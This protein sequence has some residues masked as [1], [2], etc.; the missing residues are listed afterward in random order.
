MITFTDTSV[1]TLIGFIPLVLL[2]SLASDAGEFDRLEGEALSKATISTDAVA[3][4]SLD[5]RAIDA[6]PPGLPDSRSAFLIVKTDAGNYTRLLVS[7][8]LRKP[9]AG[10]EAVPIVVID[11]FETFEPAKSGSRVAR[12]A[13]VALFE[14][15]QIDLDTGLVV[16]TGQGG[17]LEFAKGDKASVSLRPV[18]PSKLFSLSHPLPRSTAA[19]GPSTGKAVLPGDFAGRYVLHADGRWTGLLEL[20]AAADRSLKGRFRSEANGT[21]Y[22]IT[23]E[24]SSAV[25]NK[26]A[27]KVQFPRSEQEYDAFLSTE[28]KGFLSGSFVMG[29]RTFGFYATRESAETKAG[30]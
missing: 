11:R 18:K 6:L 14:A 28:G 7:P 21:A 1:K 12:G 2:F 20:E 3:H 9:T 17:D 24:V 25:P 26:A 16:P 8:G 29:D 22:P 30:P 15:F 4:E 10:G 19:P 5:F 27:F 13:G 23:G